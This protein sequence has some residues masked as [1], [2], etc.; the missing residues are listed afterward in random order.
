MILILFNFDFRP[1]FRSYKPLDDKLKE[2]QLPAIKP[3]EV[4][5]KVQDQLEA[6]KP[7]ELVEEVVGKNN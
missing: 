7:V 1:V 5:E 3:S 2:S 6:A 4:E